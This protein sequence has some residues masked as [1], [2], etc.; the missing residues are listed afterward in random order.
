MSVNTVNITDPSKILSIDEAITKAWKCMRTEPQVAIELSQSAIEAS[1]NH[2]YEL[3]L[4]RATGT[5]GASQVWVS[6]YN[7]ALNNML[8]AHA[9]L[10]RLHD[11]RMDVQVLY[12][13]SVL[14]HYLGDF[15]KQLEY[16]FEGREVAEKIKDYPGIA[17]CMNGIGTVYYSIG[18]YDKSVAIFEECIELCET[19]NINDVLSRVLDGMGQALLLKGETKKAL[20]FKKKCLIV[21]E[22]ENIAQTQ[23][24]ALRGIGEIYAQLQDYNK[25][26]EYFTKCKELRSKMGFQSG[27]AETNLFIADTYFTLKDYDSALRFVEESLE[28]ATRLES[29][30]LIYK[31]HELLSKIHEVNGNTQGFIQHFKAFQ[32]YKLQ[33]FSDRNKL[34][35]KELGLKKENEQLTNERNLLAKQ[36]T[37]FNKYKKDINLLAEIGQSLTSSLNIENVFE[38]TYA[39]VNNL[40]DANIFLI[41]LLDEENNKMV[42]NFI[43]EE[44]ERLPEAEQSLDETHRVGIWVAHNKREAIILDLEKDYAK[45]TGGQAALPSAGKQ[46]ESIIYLPILDGDKLV[47][48]ISVQSFD[49]DAYSDYHVNILRNIAV[50]VGIAVRNASTYKDV[51]AQVQIRTAQLEK[52]QE[53]LKKSHRDTIILNEIGQQLISTL[54]IDEVFNSLHTNV[55]EL[56]DASCFG[57]RLY[58]KENDEIIYKFEFEKGERHPVDKVQMSTSNNY[59]VWCVQNKK[60][61]FINDNSTEYHKYVDEVHVVKGDFPYS[62]IFQPLIKGDE[63]LGVITVQ[64]FVKNAYVERHLDILNT[65]ASYTVIALENAAIYEK[66]EQEVEKRTIE[67]KRQRDIIEMN[68]I[69]LSKQSRDVILLSEIGQKITAHLSAEK[70]IEEIYKNINQVMSVDSMGIGLVNKEKNIIEFPGYMENGKVLEGASY[71]LNDNNFLAVQCYNGEKRI[72]IN[73]YAKE[74]NLHLDSDS[75]TVGQSTSSIIYLPLYLKDEKIGV[76]TVQSFQ[77]YAYK[78][79]HANFLK[80][81][82]VFV[83]IA[84]E[85]ANLYSGLENEVAKRTSEIVQ[86]KEEIEVTHKNAQILNAVGKDLISTTDINLIFKQLHENVSQLMDATCFGIRLFDKEQNVIHYKYEIEDGKYHDDEAVVSM[87]TE[88]NYSVWCVKHKTPIMINDNSTEYIKYVKEVHVVQGSFPYSLI[89][90]PLIKG[91]EVLGVITVQS[92]EKNAYTNYHLNILEALASYS[93]IALTN[94]SMIE[95]LEKRVQE[96]TGLVTHQK[97]IIEEKNKN[98]TDSI[99]YAQRIQKAILPDINTIKAFFTDAFVIFQPKDIVSGDFYWFEKVGNKIL[100]AVVDCTGHGVPGAFMSLIGSN[101]LKRIVKEDGISDPG[102]ILDLLDEDVSETLSQNINQETVK[103]GMDLA[104]C[105]YDPETMQL[106]FAGAYNPLW[107]IRDG[108]LLDFKGEKRAIGLSDS[109]SVSNFTTHTITIKKGDQLFLSS[110]GFADQ[111]GGS[112][113][114]KL[115]I[116]KFKEMINSEIDTMEAKGEKLLQDFNLWKGDFEQLDDVCV[117]GIRV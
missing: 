33:Y 99:K 46:P 104:L 8:E 2:D 14:H 76:F 95:D 3:G 116:K 25:A 97:E 22:Q 59:S 1:K 42:Y 92:Y 43:I 71:S 56:M 84:L 40:M 94:A 114:K 112:N 34:Q 60:P 83:G 48:T 29:K 39:Q 98:I 115:K 100:F 11:L 10:S 89:F 37:A 96:R 62:L 28:L 7:N 77:K 61:I 23:S 105:A 4:A 75:E 80:N 57:I 93:V 20:E 101:A 85:N 53:E 113:N 12:M 24:Y 9:E 50:Y 109:H 52:Q 15:D 78:D 102:Q 74:F 91:G 69:E 64:S 16:C 79:Y 32:E 31:G 67:L 5:L 26:L 18:E 65:L 30:E 6:D 86:Q 90:Q 88:N 73:D 54:D 66:M 58:D 81:L 35:I 63:I 41:G 45:Y 55:N 111:F 49:K 19:Q 106:E 51:E 68:V 110:D 72:M 17:T 117:I 27:V 36:E 70:V 87:D 47:G 82:A 44:G 21:A 103:D 108:E 13:L 107:I 38:N